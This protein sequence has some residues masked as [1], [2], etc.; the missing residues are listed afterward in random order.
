MAFDVPD[1][2]QNIFTKLPRATNYALRGI[3]FS[4]TLDVVM[5]RGEGQVLPTKVG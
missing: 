5:K 4:H 2:K 1:D 3:R